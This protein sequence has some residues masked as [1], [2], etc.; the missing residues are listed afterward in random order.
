MVKEH[1]HKIIFDFSDYANSIFQRATSPKSYDSHMDIFDKLEIGAPT[2]D[3]Y[4]D[5]TPVSYSIDINFKYNTKKCFFVI[6]VENRRIPD[7]LITKFFEEVY[8]EIE[9]YIKE[10]SNLIDK[11]NSETRIESKP[12]IDIRIENE[13]MENKQKGVISTKDSRI[14][15]LHYL[16]DIELEGEEEVVI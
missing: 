9:R 11:H 3:I 1:S 7:S 5:D 13:E 12:V 16:E 6:T 8:K 10:Y 4:I 15:T 14:I 2:V